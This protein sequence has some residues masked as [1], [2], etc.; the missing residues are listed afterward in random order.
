MQNKAKMKYLVLYISMM[1]QLLVLNSC[2]ELLNLLTQMNVQEPEVNIS[3][4][5]MTGLSFDKVDL[6]FDINVNN[7]NKV[8]INLAGFDYDLLLNENSFL[9]GEQTSGL[10]IKAQ[11]QEVI[12]LPLVLNYVDIY[13]TFVSLKDLDSINYQLIT[14]L[15]FTL[16]V[17]GDIRLAIS[18]SGSVPNIKLPAIS[19]SSLKMDK[20]GFT[21]A[22]LTLEIKLKNPNAISL[23][24]KD[25]NYQLNISGAQ[26][27]QGKTSQEMDI[28]AK[29]E[30]IIEVPISLNFLNMGQSVYNLL[31]G[32]QELNYTLKGNANLASSLELLGDFKLPF[33]Q[34]GQVKIF[35]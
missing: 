8:G 33:D 25:M 21:G 18:K 4:V 1:V 24:L 22:D 17:L 13:K 31:S 30:N 27:I 5:H 35:K 29:Q 7:P 26:W 28:S 16:P 20:L 11:G 12:Q 32:H 6:L 14:G 3:N 9:K 23:L 19:L 10:E 34:S 15:A 2:S